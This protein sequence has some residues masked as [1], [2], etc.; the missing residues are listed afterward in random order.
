LRPQGVRPI[1]ELA[2]AHALEQVEVLLH[3]AIPVGAVA[4]RGGEVTA[5]L[6]D[7]LG[8]EAAHVGLPLPDERLCERVELGEVVRGE[9]ET[10]LPV[11]SQPAHVPLDGVDVVG[12]L[13]QGVG[14]VEAQV[15][16]AAEG[17]REPEV[18]ADALRVADVQKAVRLGGEAG[19]HP[20]PVF[21]GVDVGLDD[22]FEEVEVL[23][24]AGGVG[25]G[26]RGRWN[27]AA[28]AHGAASSVGGTRGAS[29]PGPTWVRSPP[30]MRPILHLE[31]IGGIAGDMF[32]AAA[33]DLGVSVEDLTRHLKGLPVP[34]W[35]LQTS[36]AS[37][38]AL[39]GTHLSVVLD[40]AEH[41]PHR[42]LP[43]IRGIIGEASTLTD[44]MKA[45]ALAVFQV[46][47]E[48]E[49]RVHDVPVERIHFHEVGAIDAIVDICGAAVALELLGDPE[50]ICAPPPL[51]SGFIRAAHG[52][53]PIPV[54]AT[55]ELL[56]GLPTRHEGVGECTTPTG[57]ALVK[58]LFR[59][60]TP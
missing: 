28:V 51:G 13:G 16:G 34:G 23:L 49:A 14:V 60:G 8:G 59:V 40:E 32:L 44:A 18:Q 39:S 2:L 9:V 27:A 15:A 11:E 53:M 25:G 29:A 31:P 58:A 1:G 12:V 38:H 4:P 7:L 22:G 6:G 30:P 50:V 24:L 26:G 36:R 20:A 41:H 21:P 17:L 19:R 35:S 3:A 54:P 57:A 45:K 10:I 48:A 55:L 37:R 33:I 46:L 47:A 52:N 42:G 43:E 5:P 56:K